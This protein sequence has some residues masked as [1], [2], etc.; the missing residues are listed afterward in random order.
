MADLARLGVII[1]PTG[2]RAGGAEV[3][4]ALDSMG[5]RAGRLN[6]SIDVLKR[7]FIALGGVFAIR[8]AFQIADDYT[9]LENRLRLVSDSTEELTELQERL[10]DLSQRTRT[11][12]VGAVELFSRMSRATQDLGTSNEDLL[13]ITETVNKAI[14]VSGAT[15]TEA[16]SAIIQF[17]QGLGLGALRGQDLKSVLSFV[18]RLAQAIADGLGVSIGQLTKLGEAGELTTEKILKA[19]E[20]QAPQIAK[21]FSKLG[22]R[23]SDS[24]TLVRNAFRNF[25]GQLDKTTGAS[26]FVTRVFTDLASVIGS[27]ENKIAQLITSFTILAEVITTTMIAR[28]LSP[29]IKTSSLYIV[30]LVRSE[31]AAFA[32]ARAEQV[33]A[34]A[35]IAG[36]RQQVAANAIT[37]GVILAQVHQIAVTNNLL[38]AQKAAVTGTLLLA[39]ANQALSISARASTIAMAVLRSALA[40]FGGPIGLAIT[41]IGLGL[42]FFGDKLFGAKDPANNLR[43]ALKDINEE[44]KTL[45]QTI[46]DLKLEKLREA[47]KLL[48]ESMAERADLPEALLPT[49]PIGLGGLGALPPGISQ[50]FAAAGTQELEQRRQGALLIGDMELAVELERRIADAARDTAEGIGD[51]KSRQDDVNETLAKGLQHVSDMR[52]QLAAFQRGGEAALLDEQALQ[53]ARDALEQTDTAINDTTRSLA[54]SIAQGR[55]LEDA[56]NDAR[57]AALHAARA[58]DEELKKSQREADQ[59]AQSA[60]DFIT[61]LQQRNRLL[62]IEA[63]LGSEAAD[64][65]R[66]RGELERFLGRDI[67]PAEQALLDDI[68]ARYQSLVT[69]ARLRNEAEQR[70]LALLARIREAGTPEFV[71]SEADISRARELFEQVNSDLDATN[72]ITQAQFDAFVR[73]LNPAASEFDRVMEGLRATTRETGEEF[74]QLSDV[75]GTAFEDALLQAKTLDDIVTALLQDISRLGLRT[76]VTEP[77]QRGLHAAFTGGSDQG[78]LFDQISGLFGFQHGGG[79]TVG[80]S[81]GPD[82]RLVAFR[83]TPGERVNVT[84]PGEGGAVTQ[85][86]TVNVDGGINSQGRKTP[87]QVAALISRELVRANRRNN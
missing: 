58:R 83:A 81:G 35:M 66:A 19:L 69:A 49:G 70:N 40:F 15:T 51:Q 50:Q 27:Q 87:G 43:D 64:M 54:A 56:L 42:V 14:Q 59:R 74:R 25:I 29:L 16:T 67:L 7:A 34:A 32:A 86:I 62:E 68:L 45:K 20:S 3:N 47:A 72:D 52:A 77:L 55:R 24:L 22:L 75:V 31:L 57:D 5:D 44:A 2:A 46:T 6:R 23:V 53:K 41:A 73:S 78:G 63:T 76:F 1:D 48:R 13:R 11:D 10:F 21:E 84:P 33:R 37:R 17:S 60:R 82:S 39:Q 71:R 4:R 30:E 18:P 61:E 38:S 9:T 80:G 28:A 36:A 65:A 79:F 85:H 8:T 26:A 12:M